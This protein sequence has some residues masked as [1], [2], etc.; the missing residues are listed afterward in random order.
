MPPSSGNLGGPVPTSTARQPTVAP[1][2]IIKVDK[3][4]PWSK[5]V[6]TKLR[7]V[8]KLPSFRENQKEAIDCTMAGKDGE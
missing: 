2:R 5:E 4:Y 8:F 3:K 6:Q 1:Q 7:Q